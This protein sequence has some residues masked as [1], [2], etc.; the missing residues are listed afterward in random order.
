MM[1]TVATP[2]IPVPVAE[3]AKGPELLRVEATWAEYIDLLNE[4]DYPIFY[5]NQT[6]ISITG[7]ASIPHEVLVSTLTYLLNRHYFNLPD[8]A[9]MGSNALIFAYRKSRAVVRYP[10]H[11]AR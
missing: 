7:Q 6:I 8:Y 10:L 3:R 5:L 11:R 4:V 9:V 2:K 1:E